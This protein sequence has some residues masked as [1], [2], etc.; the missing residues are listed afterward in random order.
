MR[1][2]LLFLLVCMAIF[3]SLFAQ[4]RPNIIL[5]M[6]DDLGYETLSCNGGRSSPATMAPTGMWYP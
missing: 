4:Q 1:Y 2:I 5:I 3:H 6:A